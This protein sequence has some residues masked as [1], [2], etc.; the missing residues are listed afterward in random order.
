MLAA[1]LA[2]GLALAA[3]GDGGSDAADADGAS[4]GTTVTVASG[5]PGEFLADADGMTLYLF[6]NDSP[7][8]S[9]CAEDCLLTWPPLLSDGAPAAG[10]G[11]DAALLATITRED[12]ST[13]VT[14]AGWPLYF[15]AGDMTQGD[16]AG[17]GVND[18]WFVLSPAGEAIR[19]AD[20]ASGADDDTS[21]GGY[22]GYSSGGGDPRY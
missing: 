18:V 19:S 6:T 17:Q 4:D 13:Q 11:V 22:S 2:M 12:G 10:Q 9:N 14:Y 15:F 21:T 20:E 16:V 7:G 5:G 8:V 1:S 3:C